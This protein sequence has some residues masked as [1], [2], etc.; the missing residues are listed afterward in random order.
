VQ[1]LEAQKKRA[2][3][4][5]YLESNGCGPT[6][7]E[8]DIS[9]K[10]AVQALADKK[11]VKRF[12]TDNTLDQIRKQKMLESSRSSSSAITSIKNDI[13]KQQVHIIVQIHR[14]NVMIV[15]G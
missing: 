11:P 8:A 15:V 6:S 14:L 7:F 13:I 3:A 5:A 9:S 1:E 2:A 12:T 4:L 10:G